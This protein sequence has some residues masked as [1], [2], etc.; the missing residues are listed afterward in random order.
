[1]KSIKFIAFAVLLMVAAGPA[2]SANR[3]I[4]PDPAQA[5]ADLAAALKTA[6][7]THKRILL[8]FGGNWCGDCQVL[9]LYFHDP[10]NRPILEANF[11]LVHINIGHMDANTDI[12]ETYQIPLKRGVPALAVLSEKGTLLYSQKSGEF[13][14]MRNLESTALTTFLV[15]WKPTREG[16]SAVMVNC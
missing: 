6:A 12:A 10:R 14:S 2:Q 15:Q 3:Q 11:V 1:M 13:E 5:K 16:C 4:Y 7:Q 8:D 9:D